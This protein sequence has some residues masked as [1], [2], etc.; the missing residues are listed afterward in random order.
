[1]ADIVELIAKLSLQVGDNAPLQAQIEAFKKQSAAIDELAKKR[2]LLERVGAKDKNAERAA[3]AKVEVD[4]LNKSIE[5]QTA[6]LTKQVSQQQ[7]VTRAAT[8]ELGIIQKLQDR[9]ADLNRARESQTTV[10]G[11]KQINAEVSK[12]KSELN[13]LQDANTSG[14]G[15]GIFA[16]LLGTGGNATTGRQI[17]QGVLAG[18]GIGVGFSVIPALV[19]HLIE[20]AKA[21][22]DVSQKAI[23]LT[24]N[25]EKLTSSFEGL[26]EQA[27][28]LANQQ[29]LLDLFNKLNPAI[30]GGI[31]TG[32]PQD[33]LAE[34]TAGIK[35]QAEETEALGVINGKVYEAQI[36]DL[37]AANDV[38]R[39]EIKDIERTQSV[40]SEFSA[41]VAQLQNTVGGAITGEKPLTSNFGRTAKEIRDIINTL[42][43][44]QLDRDKYSAE[45]QKNEGDLVE[46]SLSLERIR[47]DF[48][49]KEVEQKQSK[50]DKL[51]EI[52]KAEE[53][54]E[55]ETN[56]KVFELNKKLAIEIAA[57]RD[58]LALADIARQERTMG[59]I[60]KQFDIQITA[61]RRATALELKEAENAGAL[62]DEVRG[63][64]E[65]KAAIEHKEINK[66]RVEA[67]RV[68]NIA[69]LQEQQ[70]LNEQLL[71]AELASLAQR[72]SLLSGKELQ[73]NI[74]LRNNV[75]EKEL[76]LQQAANGA[77]YD[78]QVRAIDKR[79]SET[80]KESKAYQ[81]LL[82][83]RNN[84]FAEYAQKQADLETL[85]AAKRIKNIQSGYADVIAVVEVESRKLAAATAK[86]F[87]EETLSISESNVGL[88]G[89][90]FTKRIAGLRN[91]SQVEL[92][93]IQQNSKARI[94]AA[95]ALQ[96]ATDLNDGTPT[97][98]K[99]VAEAQTALDN[100]D[101]AINNSNAKINDN[102]RQTTAA[103][104][105]AYADAAQSILQ[106]AQQ[107]YNTLQQYRMQDLDRQIGVTEQ[108][109]QVGLA[110]AEKGNTQL[111]DSET[112]R[113]RAEQQE[114][115][116]SA[117]EQQAMNT[118]LQISY[119]F[120]AIAK[121]T[122]EG[123]GIASIA[124]VAAAVGALI[125]GYALVRAANMNAQT[126]GFAEGGF[127]GTGGKYQPAGV[128]HRGEFVM[129]QQTTAKYRP[130]FEHIHKTG[131]L[132]AMGVNRKEFEQLTDA[133]GRVENAVLNS[134]VRVSQ[135]FDANGM[136][137]IV[138]QQRHKNVIKYKS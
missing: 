92:N 137:Q 37:N 97:G 34:T 26:E 2:D 94:A 43:I 61:S 109:L 59:N 66:N 17:I 22:Y 10:A 7:L 65:Q 115:R 134:R 91:A 116:K 20:F 49:A 113:L 51:S 44:S 85:V 73:G 80:N 87:S 125:S 27:V 14:G 31:I 120:L 101:A 131:E 84:I 15:K 28:K 25:V 129:N 5:A 127:T 76:Q 90:D 104:V 72:L 54:L 68:L 58:K 33:V 81:D 130:L 8:Q 108:R 35:R 124:T 105:V 69:L 57:E 38:R 132:P 42:P 6:A 62:T 138:E 100:L 135:R 88:F 93:S 77:A 12:L 102:T 82:T 106:S 110:L 128:V 60:N 24:Q 56:A 67:I 71:Q 117:L 79:L 96:Q 64:I 46:F 123:G 3:R 45:L 83:T 36:R 40:L 32:L 95:K 53:K 74:D 119:S 29:R 4:K 48:A 52:K 122:A 1:M 112:K 41:K 23:D 47:K 111:L 114:R 103:Y 70:K 126:T 99:A 30:A 18:A 19:S 98:M 21:E 9:L 16:S 55:S 133:V 121:A 39:S 11:I 86:G 50:L 89:M 13:E 107:M 136:H 78:E 118:A 63:K 75:T